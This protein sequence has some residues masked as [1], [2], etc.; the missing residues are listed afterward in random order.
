MTAPLLDVQ[1]LE[2]SLNAGEGAR[3]LV[4]DL[5]FRIDAGEALCLVGESG[6]GKSVTA[7]ALMGLLDPKKLRPTAG[8][9]MFEGQDLLALPPDRMRALRG[10]RIAMVFQEPMSALNPVQ[11][12]GDQIAETIR[13]HRGTSA[14]DAERQAV[15]LLD[16]VQVPDAKRRAREYPHQLSGGM[17]Q[18]VM[19]AMAVA[20]R[21]SLLIADEPTTA[22]DVTIQAQVLSLIDDLRRELGTAVL[23]ITHD[24]GVVAEIADR[25]LV[26]YAGRAVE[27]A[28]VATLFDAPEHP[29]TAALIQSIRHLQNFAEGD[30]LIEIPGGMPAPGR[31]VDGCAFAERCAYALADCG[32]RL[33]EFRRRAPEHFAACWRTP[34][35]GGAGR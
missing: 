3:P 1:G 7:L 20:L 28:P 23:L 26:L 33:P 19:I 25:V 15:D 35:F 4:R 9:A 11:R 5:S 16:L 31:M 10:H 29:Y 12:I 22:L 24:L 30:R 27:Q 13:E 32:T 14:R 6:S 8:R 21:P 17:R 2:I 18:R 34:P